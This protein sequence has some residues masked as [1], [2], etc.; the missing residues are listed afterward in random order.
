MTGASGALEISVRLLY[1]TLSQPF[2]DDLENTVTDL[3]NSFMDMYRQMTNDPVVLVEV[4]PP[5]N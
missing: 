5:V 4:R 2:V 3:V 1:Q